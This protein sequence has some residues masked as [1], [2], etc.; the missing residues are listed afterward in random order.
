[1]KKLSLVVL[2]V[3]LLGGVAL[4]QEKPA[5][6]FKKTEHNFGTIKE[7]IGNVSTQFE[8][9]NTGKS[10]LVIQRVS[11]S[12][13]CTTPSY[14]KEPILPGKAGKISATYSTVRRPGTFNKTIR[15]YTNV[16]DTVY[17]LTIKGNVTPA[18]Q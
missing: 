8:F 5:M 18:K 1:M 7:E 12:C 3:V 11:A 6:N 13:G 10:P 15:V 2:L 4:A 9:T 14:T 17:V 16:P